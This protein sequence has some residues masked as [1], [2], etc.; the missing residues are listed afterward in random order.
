MV[1]EALFLRLTARIGIKKRIDA[2]RAYHVETPP[3]P[4]TSSFATYGIDFLSRLI[5]EQ[6]FHAGPFLA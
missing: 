2:P 6:L 1:T 5:T 3:Q 4:L